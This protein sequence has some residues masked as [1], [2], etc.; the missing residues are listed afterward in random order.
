M[1]CYQCKKEFIRSYRSQKYC[2]KECS[3]HIKN[4]LHRK[5]RNTDVSKEYLKKYRQTD[6]YKEYLK[7][8]RQTDKYKEYKKKYYQTNNGKKLRYISLKKYYQSNKGKAYVQKYE[9]SEKCKV[10]RNTYKQ[11]AEG[12]KVRKKSSLIYHNNKIKSDPVYKL[13]RLVRSRLHNFLNFTADL[14]KKEKTFK[15]VGCSPKFLK[16]YLEKK[17]KTGMNWQNN[18]PKGWH[19]DHTIPLNSAKTIEDIEKLS[20]YTNL[21]PMWALAN[22]KK[23]KKIN[24][25]G[26]NQNY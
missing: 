18:S 12:K 10:R 2:S 8:Y 5:Y 21:Q 16:K 13:S 4:L 19:I 6:K 24:W 20:H 17:F 9:Q 14:K 22:L 3:R 26:K 1:I 11:S 23:G 15:M 25:Q 7:K